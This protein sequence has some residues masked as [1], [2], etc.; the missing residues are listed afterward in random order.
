[1]AWPILQWYDLANIVAVW[2]GQ[3]C[4]GVARPILWQCGQAYT[5]AVWPGLYCGGVARPI[6]WNALPST[7]REANT[8]SPKHISRYSKYIKVSF[9]HAK[10]L[11]NCKFLTSGVDLTL[12]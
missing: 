11:T 6:L 3:Y 8:V 10:V 4:G 2:P 5:V 12:V 1:M 7:V 9:H